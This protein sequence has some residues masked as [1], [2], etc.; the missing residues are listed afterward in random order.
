MAITVKL[1]EAVP[2]EED[3]VQAEL[4]AQ[5]KMYVKNLAER[6]ECDYEEIAKQI[7]LVYEEKSHPI[8]WSRLDAY[9][10]I[11]DEWG[12]IEAQFMVNIAR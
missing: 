1:L 2:R 8:Q 5:A 10:T 3:S 7:T 11:L 9:L 4:Y 6:F 12:E